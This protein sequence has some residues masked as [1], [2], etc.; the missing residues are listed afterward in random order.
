MPS[1]SCDA[2]DPALLSQTAEPRAGLSNFCPLAPLTTFCESVI[3]QAWA[4][5]KEEEGTNTRM[6]NTGG[7]SV[8]I[9]RL[10]LN[11]ALL[12]P[13]FKYF[14]DPILCECLWAKHSESEKINLKR[15]ELNLPS[16]KVN[17]TYRKITMVT[18]HLYVIPTPTRL[19]ALNKLE[20]GNLWG[21]NLVTDEVWRH[22]DVK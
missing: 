10:P 17:G 9:K 6:W 15:L 20:S 5:Y 18:G 4:F 1:H 22:R 2:L 19:L 21:G 7:K 3:S 13:L 12:I 8:T 11:K 14:V 16:L